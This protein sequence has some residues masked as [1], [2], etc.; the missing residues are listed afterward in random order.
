MVSCVHS[1]TDAAL[2][3]YV[4]CGERRL[5]TTGFMNHYGASGKS[6]FI[7][8]RP[9]CNLHRLCVCVCVRACVWWWWWWWG[10]GGG[11]IPVEH[12]EGLPDCVE[13]HVVLIEPSISIISETIH[14]I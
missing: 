10:W 4:Y 2:H 1:G 14:I 6:V 12:M 8:I 11:G 7:I 13:L 5:R 9:V 3:V